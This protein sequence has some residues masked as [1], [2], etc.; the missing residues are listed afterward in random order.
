MVS[1]GTMIFINK[2]GFH[3]FYNYKKKKA[4]DVGGSTIVIHEQTFGGGICYHRW[5]VCKWVLE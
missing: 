4:S 2:W 3:C 5:V 1:M